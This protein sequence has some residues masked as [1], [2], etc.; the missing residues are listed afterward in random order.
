M[1][2]PRTFAKANGWSRL[3]THAGAGLQRRLRDRLIGRQLRVPG[4]RAG[5]AP[6]LLGLSHMHIGPDFNAG[7]ALWLEAVLAYKA[8]QFEPRLTIGSH[9]RLSDSVH[10]ACLQRITIGAHLLCGSHA[11]ISDHLHG[12]YDESSGASDPAVPPSE[13]SLHSPA[14]VLIGEN[15]WLGDGVA[16]LAGAEI[17]DGCVIGANA[18]VNS[19]IPSRTVAVGAPARPVRWWDERS[20]VWRPVQSQPAQ[21]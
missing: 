20:G 5:R 15:V 13:R 21:T 6:R 14:P 7:D 3:V 4:F 10:I 12:R 17:G 11:L 8:Q 18:V 1:N 16:V 9:A 19:P 2:D